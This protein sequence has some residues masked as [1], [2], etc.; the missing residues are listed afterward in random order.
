MFWVDLFGNSQACPE[1]AAH[2]LFLSF[3]NFKPFGGWTDYSYY[4]TYQVV[5]ACGYPGMQVFKN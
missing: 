3:N 5:N 1:L 4:E 2:E